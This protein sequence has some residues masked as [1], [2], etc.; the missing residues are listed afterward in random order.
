MVLDGGSTDKTLEIAKEKKIPVIAA[1]KG[2]GRAFKF[3]IENIHHYAPDAKY[4]TI[5]DGDGT[6]NLED[7]ITLQK[8]QPKDMIIGKR[9][10]D[11]DAATV[12]RRL[13]NW[14][15][16]TTFFL[17]Y[18]HNPHDL[19]SG[20]RIMNVEK[21]RQI[22]IQY[23]EFELETE[24]T[25]KFL[26]KKWDTIW[27]PVDYYRRFGNSKLR[28]WTDGWKILKSMIQLRFQ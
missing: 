25:V 4:I 16:N 1:P 27:I 8:Y 10:Y 5:I 9:R 28:P 6:Y 15:L 26:Q 23:D 17:L 7:I 14:L 24:L 20:F 12:L 22:S 2:K 11:P 3:F 18:Q 13:G 19:L 21:L